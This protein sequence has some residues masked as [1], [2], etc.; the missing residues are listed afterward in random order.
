M[1]RRLCWT[2]PIAA[3]PLLLV[4][5]PSLGAQQ[6]VAP[7]S[8]QL[9]GG[10]PDSAANSARFDR[11]LTAALSVAGFTV[12]PTAPTDTAWRAALASVGG[13]FDPHTGKAVPER[14]RTV[15][16]STLAP[17][18]AGAGATLLLSSRIVFVTVGHQDDVVRWD[19]VTERI[20]GGAANAGQGGITALS[21]V[22]VASDST[23]EPVHCG[24]GG[25]QLLVKGNF[26]HAPR[27]VD[28]S[29]ILTDPGKDSTAVAVALG[30]FIAGRPSCEGTP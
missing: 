1:L 20:G 17:F 18:Q 23:G 15:R 24:R 21:L 29:K 5:V 3:L 14:L 26:W 13:Y 25:I 22:L 11:L 19:G 2:A 9:P 10:A 8:T 30:G 7:L 4:A 12:L 6:V 27:R 28:D 16:V